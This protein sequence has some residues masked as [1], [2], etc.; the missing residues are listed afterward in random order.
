MPQDGKKTKVSAEKEKLP[1]EKMH[2]SEAEASEA[3]D[4]SF[5]SGSEIDEVKFKKRCLLHDFWL[6]GEHNLHKINRL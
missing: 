1:Q 2:V 4:P 6:C 3:E 5:N